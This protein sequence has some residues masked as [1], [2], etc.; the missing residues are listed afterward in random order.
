MKYED[1]R[2]SYRNPI[3]QSLLINELSQERERE[4]EREGTSL[5]QL[6]STFVSS[7]ALETTG[8]YFG[9]WHW[10]VAKKWK[11]ERLR[12]TVLRHPNCVATRSPTSI[13]VVTNYFTRQIN[14]NRPA[15]PRKLM[16]TL[17]GQRGG[18]SSAPRWK[19]AADYFLAFPL[20]WR[21]K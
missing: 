16:A 1:S 2:T 21:K 7:S 17:K 13:F 3:S 15:L 19:L 11:S 9:R 10:A 18:I 6:S 8:G 12:H 20:P 14:A 5:V 4:R